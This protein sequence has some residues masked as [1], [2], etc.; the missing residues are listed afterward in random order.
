MTEW[1]RLISKK[2]SWRRN[3]SAFRECWGSEKNRE[4]WKIDSDVS[5]HWPFSSPSCLDVT[6]FIGH[7]SNPFISTC[8]CSCAYTCFIY[9]KSYCVYIFS[10]IFLHRYRTRIF[11]FQ[12]SLYV[13]LL[14]DF[15]NSIHQNTNL[16]YRIYWSKDFC[17]YFL[18][19]GFFFKCIQNF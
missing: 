19:I 16:K 10:G 1:T 2:G 14:W 8:V 3:K 13:F 18:N 4:R 9:I 5:H 12:I 7:I 15:L 17:I 6:T 11:K